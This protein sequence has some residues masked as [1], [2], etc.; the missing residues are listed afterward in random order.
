MAIT[1]TEKAATRVRD[2]LGRRGKGA[3]L[4]LALKDAGCSGKSYVVEYA[5]AIE[6]TDQVFESHGVKIIIDPKNLVFL[7]GME[8]DYTREGLNEGFR[9][10]N[11]NEKG[12]CGCGESIN[13]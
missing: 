12:R 11:P 6:P 9:F 5:D 13:V 7:D 8:I 3:G 1:L 10:I 4:R 2:F